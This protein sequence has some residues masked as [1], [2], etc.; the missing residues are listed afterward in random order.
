M[1]LD[2]PAVDQD[3]AGVWAVEAGQDAG[4][5]RLPGAVLAQERM[6]LAVASFEVDSIVGQDAWEA[7]GD[8]AHGHRRDGPGGGAI[9]VYV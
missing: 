7:L 2:P 6:D 5:R 4:E 1:E 8:R 3:L 9:H